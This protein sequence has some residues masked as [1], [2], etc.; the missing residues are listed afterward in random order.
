MKITD[1]IRG[2]LDLIDADQENQEPKQAL[3]VPDIAAQEDELARIAQLAGLNTDKDVYN[4]Q[5][6]PQVR[7]VSAVLA[8]GTDVNKSKHPADIRTNAPSM[9]PDFQARDNLDG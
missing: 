6:D 2:I 8:T 9:F 7:S 5:P 4:N 1:I 3:I